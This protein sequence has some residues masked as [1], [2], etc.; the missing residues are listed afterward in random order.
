MHLIDLGKE[1]RHC[2]NMRYLEVYSCTKYKSGY[3]NFRVREECVANHA[4]IVGTIF[5]L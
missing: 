4:W 3:H 2:K 1:D 5:S